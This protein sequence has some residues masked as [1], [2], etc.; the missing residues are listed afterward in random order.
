MHEL[1]TEDDHMTDTIGFIGLG[2]L[3]SSIAANLL[4]AGYKLRVYNR[5]ASETESFV[6]RAPRARCA[7]AMRWSPTDSS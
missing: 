6:D 4:E 7:P 1:Q 5:T 2:N 3:G